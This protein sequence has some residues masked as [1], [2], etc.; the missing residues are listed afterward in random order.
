MFWRFAT[1]SALSAQRWRGVGQRSAKRTPAAPARFND[2]NAPLSGPLSLV[3][4]S[5][6]LTA[7]G[8][9]EFVVGD[10]GVVHGFRVVGR[11][12]SDGG[13]SV[14]WGFDRAVR[15]DVGHV[16][17]GGR[18]YLRHLPCQRIRNHCGFPAVWRNAVLLW[19]L[20]FH[21][22]WQC[23][24]G[25]VFFIVRWW[26]VESISQIPALGLVALEK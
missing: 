18:R 16:G 26:P 8:G 12:G 11:V 1:A 13:V 2:A 22:L 19:C 20:G 24:Y 7:H 23:R 17:R 15:V 9:H 5:A 10:G 4:P 6:D 21:P 14:A 25:R 3:G